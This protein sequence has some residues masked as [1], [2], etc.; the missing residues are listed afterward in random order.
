LY[1]DIPEHL[2]PDRSLL[3]LD[4]GRVRDEV[5]RLGSEGRHHEAIAIIEDW[6]REVGGTLAV[7]VLNAPIQVGGRG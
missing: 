6:E 2:Q 1:A 7:R 5:A 4:L 3:F